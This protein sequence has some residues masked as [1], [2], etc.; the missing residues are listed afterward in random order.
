[1]EL[2]NLTMGVAAGVSISSAL[3]VTFSPRPIRML[4]ALF[5]HL[6]ANFVL[7][8]FLKADF[9]ALAYLLVFLGGIFVWMTGFITF[10]PESAS[11][12]NVS[13]KS[14]IVIRHSV[15]A[16]LSISFFVLLAGLIFSTPWPIVQGTKATNLIE[17][18][19]A[20]F[21]TWTL[22]LEWI[23]WFWT[24]TLIGIICLLRFSPQ[25]APIKEESQVKNLAA[26]QTQTAKLEP[27]KA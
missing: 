18:G 9:L 5:F 16:F 11:P 21:E 13:K 7:L 1:M 20:L 26:N 24:L 25:P 10:F 23:A 27:D 19:D 2:L 8:L 17:F 6:A 12:E 22:P 14:Y 15:A 4:K 3:M